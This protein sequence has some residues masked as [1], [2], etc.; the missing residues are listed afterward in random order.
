MYVCMYTAELAILF[1]K[2]N[3]SEKIKSSL[4]WTYVI[5]VLMALLIVKIKTKHKLNVNQ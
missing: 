4:H 1:L 3:S 5:W 2:T